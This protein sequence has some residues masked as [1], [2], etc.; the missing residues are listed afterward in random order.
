M[1]RSD[2]SWFMR[3]G[4]DGVSSSAVADDS[5]CAF[6]GSPLLI[7]KPARDRPNRENTLKH[8]RFM[9]I[10]ALRI[11]ARGLLCLRRIRTAGP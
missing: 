11:V 2:R 8:G 10:S 9:T 3:I 4:A 6:D 7:R 1:C 5:R